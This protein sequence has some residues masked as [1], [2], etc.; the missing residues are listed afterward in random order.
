VIYPLYPRSFQDSDGDGVGDLN[1]ILQ[2]LD[3]LNDGSRRSLSIDAILLLPT[4]GSPMVDFGYDVSDYCT[5]D[6]LF[7]SL[8]TQD[9]DPD[10]LLNLYRRLSQLKH[11]AAAQS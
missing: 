5:V 8:D 2:R 10:S 1:G 9:A 11:G 3:Y 4:F 7:G 6:P